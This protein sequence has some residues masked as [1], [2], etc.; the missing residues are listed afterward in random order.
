MPLRLGLRLFLGLALGFRIIARHTI[1][2]A[3]RI[4]AEV[5]SHI[6]ETVS[7]IG[8]AKTFRQ[9]A[10][11]HREF[12]D[13]NTQSGRVNLRSRYTFS[14]IFPLLNAL[15]AIGTGLLVYFGGLQVLD[16]VLTAGIFFLFIQGLQ[17]F[18]FPLTSI[19]SFW[20]QFQLGLAA[21]ER[22]FALIDAE[23][24]V[25]QTDNRDPGKLRGA[26]T[27]ERINFAYKPGTPVLQEF[28]LQIRAGE[29]QVRR[30][31]ALEQERLLWHQSDICAKVRVADR[32]D[33]NA[34]DL[35][36]PGLRCVEAQQQ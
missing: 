36:P 13:V 10:A 23:P 8:V 2:A 26:I 15:A 22:V 11:I 29:Q 25:I 12:L 6:Q 9:E 14:L 18:W 21:G 35:Y 19:A 24:R 27:F 7:G 3:R 32:A 34:V 5:S 33:R 4:N 30:D 16:G 1:T 17:N 20:S 31:G 28:N